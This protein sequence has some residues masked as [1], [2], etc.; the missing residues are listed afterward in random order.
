MCKSILNLQLNHV[1]HYIRVAGL[2]FAIAIA[3]YKVCKPYSITQSRMPWDEVGFDSDTTM[4]RSHGDRPSVSAPLPRPLPG[5]V[6]WPAKMWCDF[7]NG[8]DTATSCVLLTQ[9]FVYSSY[10][11]CSFSLLSL[12]S[13]LRVFCFPDTFQSNIFYRPRSVAVALLL[14]DSGSRAHKLPIE[15]STLKLRHFEA[16]SKIKN[17][18]KNEL[19]MYVVTNCEFILAAP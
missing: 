19:K 5:R 1:L 7:I 15:L 14:S 12:F 9:N 13:R 8:Q 4:K 16:P 17:M 10:L 3:F 2:V 6:M 18:R 11:R